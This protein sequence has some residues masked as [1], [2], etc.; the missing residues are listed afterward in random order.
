MSTE[1]VALSSSPNVS[2]VV[3]K[4]VDALR[5]G[6]LVVLPTE[7]VYGIAALASNSD[8]V[9]RLCAEKRRAIGRPLSIAIWGREVLDRYVPVVPSNALRLAERFW[10]GPLTLVLD[11]SDPRSALH[12]LPEVSRKIVTPQKTVG[13]RVP[14]NEFTL[15]VLKTLDEPIVLSSANYSGNRPAVSPDEAK[16]ALGESPDLI[17]DDGNALYKTPSSVVKFDENRWSILRE[18]VLLRDDIQEALKITLVFAYSENSLANP[19]SDSICKSL[20]SRFAGR[21]EDEL[22]EFG[23]QLV[24]AEIPRDDK[25]FDGGNDATCARSQEINSNC[26]FNDELAQRCD[27][28]LAEDERI[29]SYILSRYPELDKKVV[30]ADWTT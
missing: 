13:I 6:K 22:E 29:K 12:R 25:S 20:L 16:T 23:F 24:F 10:P 9:E 5:A 17:I 30:L 19:P 21:R 3:A 18:G 11:A 27:V 28:I 7:T 1:Y 15:N 8:A 26:K 2:L 4:C 14:Q